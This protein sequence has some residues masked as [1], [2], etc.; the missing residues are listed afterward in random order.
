MQRARK[1]TMEMETE[2]ETEM[3]MEMGF[4]RTEVVVM[5]KRCLSSSESQ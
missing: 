4:G 1:V 3:G 2:M 5:R